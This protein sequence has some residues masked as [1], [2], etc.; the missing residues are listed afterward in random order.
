VI[1]E[2]SQRALGVM[3][4]NNEP[5]TM[6]VGRGQM[7][8]GKRLDVVCEHCGYKGYQKENCYRI[9]GYPPDFKRKRKSMH[10][11]GSGGFKT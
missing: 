10:E 2:E 8:K 5:L 3:D 7:M 11:K 9:V 6:L 4:M 1:Q